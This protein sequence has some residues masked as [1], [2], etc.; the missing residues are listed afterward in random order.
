MSK[1]S[2]L[3][4]DMQAE[5]DSDKDKTTNPAPTGEPT[6]APTEEPA[7]IDEPKPEDTPAPTDEP[8]PAEETKP[9]DEPKPAEEPKPTEEPARKK[10]SEYTPQERAE[11]AFRRQ[12]AKEKEKH[13]KEIEE[14]KGTLQKQI[15]ELKKSTA[16]KPALKTRDD[17]P[18]D[19]SYIKYLAQVQVDAIMAD[20][21]AKAAEAK[22]KQDAEA[23]EIA[24]QQ[25]ELAEQQKAWLSN[26][27][28]A[29]GEDVNRKKA[30]LKRVEY[31]NDR[32]LGTILDN[33]P[34][35]S[36]FLMNNPRGPIVFEKLLMDRAAFERVFN[37]RHLNP[38]DIY[39]ELRQ[40]DTE[41]KSE[42]NVQTETPA[43]PQPNAMPHLGKPGKAGGSSGAPDIF[44]DAKAMKAWLRSH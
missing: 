26:V 19:D 15:D 17:F 31:C 28:S 4:E 16:P 34:V 18:D 20:R 3:M 9:T 36:D 22:E 10:P 29:F 24:K 6:P 40:I 38:M 33:C 35:A 27:D 32:G 1:L 5:L 8:K 44:S 11:Y 13:A 23:A 39:Y 41:L 42:Q 21:D 12:L 37:E 14:L 7:P 43:Q 30:F 25:E 2:K